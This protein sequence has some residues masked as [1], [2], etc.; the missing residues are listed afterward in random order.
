MP[1]FKSA[2][3]FPADFYHDTWHIALIIAAYVFAY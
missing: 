3:F 2:F 1:M